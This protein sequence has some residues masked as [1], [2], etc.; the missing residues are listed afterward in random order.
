MEDQRIKSNVNKIPTLDSDDLEHHFE[1]AEENE[2]SFSVVL[3]LTGTKILHQLRDNNTCTKEFISQNLV[4]LT[5]T[6]FACTTTAIGWIEVM[7][8]SNR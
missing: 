2:F 7:G 6:Q 5:R 8:V 4:N 3:K 1:W